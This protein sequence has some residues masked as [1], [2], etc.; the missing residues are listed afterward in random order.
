VGA[1]L[2]ANESLYASGNLVYLLETFI[3]SEN[4]TSYA[5]RGCP[6]FL[7]F[8]SC[9]F[10]GLFTLDAFGSGPKVGGVSVLLRRSYVGSPLLF[11]IAAATGACRL[12]LDATTLAGG[13]SYPNGAPVELANTSGRSLRYENTLLNPAPPFSQY[14]PTISRL[15]ALNVQAAL[16]ELTSKVN[17]FYHHAPVTVT[18]TPYLVLA[19]NS[20]FGV[21]TTVPASPID[22]V[23][24]ATEANGA[25]D[26]RVLYVKDEAGSAGVPARQINVYVTG[27]T[28]TIDGVVRNAGAPLVLNT[29]YAGLTLMC[30][31]EA[32]G[33]SSWYVI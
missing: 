15:S 27:A 32:G 14:V 10:T 21:D 23:L 29:N 28:G 19:P 22:I 18:T 30:R 24:P 6:D 25:V 4:G 26:G 1:A 2:K 20:Y 13:L 11:D 9:Q 31:G 3:T 16:D 7:I 33:T 8:L 12:L 5:L 17:P